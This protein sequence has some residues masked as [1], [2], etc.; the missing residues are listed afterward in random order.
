MKIVIVGGGIIGAA[1]ARTLSVAGSDVT[2]FESAPGA[3]PASFGW[4]NASFYLNADHFALRAAGL[5]AWRRL[6]GHVKWNGCLCWEEE[7]DAFDTQRD[8]LAALGYELEEV[9]ANGF[10]A[11]EP[12]IAP[13]PRALH[14]RQ[15]G[16]ASPSETARHLLDGV[17][18]VSGVR[19]TGLLH[20]GDVITGIDTDQGH[21][22]ADRVI[23]AAG[24]G[25]PALLGSVGV[26]LPMLERP[27]LMM[28]TASVAPILNHVL[29]A[30][31]QE[32]R[33]DAKGHI[34]A[35]T[36]ANHQSDETSQVNTRPDLLA[37][38]AL[39]RIQTLLP[40]HRLAW[41]RVMLAQRPVPQDGLPVMGPCGP[42]GLFAAVM[43]SGITLAAITAELVAPQVLGQSLSNAQSALVA[44]F[45]PDRFQSG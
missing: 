32:L 23:V 27:G 10:A 42:K 8:R 31:G 14:F 20:R 2:V 30:P 25:S 19:V 16:I 5:N 26:V 34:W 37:D 33:Q 43:H 29:V 4:V 13:P 36:A 39:A 28:R 1:L 35:P 9:D 44:A 40:G 38:A 41:D 24:I 21:V 45:S 7:G 11:L 22:P 17:R 6:G 15:E 12:H 3:T 18:R